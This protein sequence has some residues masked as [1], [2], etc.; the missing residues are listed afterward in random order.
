MRDMQT[1]TGYFYAVYVLAAGIFGGY[2]IGIVLAARK[3]KARLDAA[4]ARR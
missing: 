1:V 4:T 3:A 2:A